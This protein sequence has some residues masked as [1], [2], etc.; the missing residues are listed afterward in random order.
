M[1]INKIFN[2]DCYEEEMYVKEYSVNDDFMDE[3]IEV[4]EIYLLLV[5]HIYLL[6]FFLNPLSSNLYRYTDYYNMCFYDATWS[7]NY[8]KSLKYI[9]FLVLIG[10]VVLCYL[11]NKSDIIRKIP[12][13]IS[14]KEKNQA[15]FPIMALLA[16][17]DITIMIIFFI[18]KPSALRELKKRVERVE[19]KNIEHHKKQIKLYENDSGLSH[20]AENNKRALKIAKDNLNN[21]DEHCNNIWFK[22]TQNL[23]PCIIMIMVYN[24]VI[25]LDLF[26]ENEPLVYILSTVSFIISFFWMGYNVLNIA[27]K[28]LRTTVGLFFSL[29]VFIFIFNMLH[30][31]VNEY[32][33]VFAFLFIM[34]ML[35]FM[36]FI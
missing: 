32:S 5:I 35:L 7:W 15:K 21:S 10:L 29:L 3:G 36:F 34:I 17:Y 14:L 18:Y 8:P 1:I 26:K 30:K 6:L 27:L 20:I 9:L 25:F 24:I 22:N 2:S 13:L 31:L 4:F 23:F 11:I 28:F 16:L 12:F 19:L 33:F